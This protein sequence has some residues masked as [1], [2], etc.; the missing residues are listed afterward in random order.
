M[1][2][3]TEAPEARTQPPTSRDCR[4]ALAWLG[5]MTCTQM[6]EAGACYRIVVAV[7]QNSILSWG[8]AV[9]G[10]TSLKRERENGREP[11]LPK[12]RVFSS[13]LSIPYQ[14]SI[15]LTTVRLRDLQSCSQKHHAI[16]IIYMSALPKPLL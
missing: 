5:N 6:Q 3:P 4:P 11:Q 2:V 9:E 16:D 13:Y 14:Y 8:R 15:A 7:Y 1:Q 12:P 10:G